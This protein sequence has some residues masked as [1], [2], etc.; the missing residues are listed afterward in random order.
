MEHPTVEHPTVERPTVERQ[1]VEYI[2]SERPTME[3]PAMI[4]LTVESGGIAAISVSCKF[5]AAKPH[6]IYRLLLTDITL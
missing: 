3:R 6:V 2:K 4:H 1:A 5:K